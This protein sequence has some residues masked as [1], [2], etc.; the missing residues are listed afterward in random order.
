MIHLSGPLPADIREGIR[1]HGV[2]N[3]HLTAI[4][5]TGTISLLANAI[6][7]GLEHAYACQ[8]IRRLR[9][10]DGLVTTHAITDHAYRLFRELYGDAPLRSAFISAERIAP[11]VHLDMQVALQPFVDNAISKTITVPADYGFEQFRS[12]YDYA[13]DKG[14]KGCT[15]FRPNPATGAVLVQMKEDGPPIH[16]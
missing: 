15:T 7:S 9:E 8:Y 10:T 5:P 11:K 1:R 16:C 4:A 12:L 14:L 2:R 6:S 3:S 13:Y